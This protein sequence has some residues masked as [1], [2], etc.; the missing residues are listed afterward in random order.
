MEEWRRVWREGF[1]PSLPTTALER[2]LKAI[3][4]DDERLIQGQTTKPP[5]LM[6]V[7][8]WP[9]EAGCIL[10]YMGVAMAGGFCP[11]G[12]SVKEG[13]ATVK[14]A[15]EF[16]V[17]ACFDAD[18]ILG[19]PAACLWF[20]NWYDDVTRKEMRREMIYEVERELQRR[21]SEEKS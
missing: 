19:A 17:K 18:Q 3:V 11:T 8:D 4:D 13:Y 2:L 16:F 5:P 6:C 21:L 20:L 9:C 7:Q 14:D 12:H 1:C 15:E 10:G